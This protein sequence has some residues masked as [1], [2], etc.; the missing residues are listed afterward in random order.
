MTA[1][2]TRLEPPRALQWVATIP[3][4]WVFKICHT[5]ELHSIDNDR[6]QFINYEQL[7][8]FLVPFVIS[9]DAQQG[10]E[11]MNNALAERAE[12]RFGA[13]SESDT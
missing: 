1:T 13:V 11:A 3:F 4:S 7:S 9:A 10:Y 2:I 8:S 5:F 12:Q 6:T